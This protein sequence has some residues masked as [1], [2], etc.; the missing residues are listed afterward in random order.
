[1]S[2]FV[3]VFGGSTVQP[4]DVAF[5]A[6]TL[7]ASIVLEWPQYSVNEQPLAR[8]MDIS[9]A[10]AA[11]SVTL[12]D[13]RAVTPGADF[14]VTNRGS[15]NLPIL[16]AAGANQATL[17]VGASRYFYLTDN[18]TEAGTWA[19]ML[20]GA[21]SATIDASQLAGRG[22]QARG[23]LLDTTVLT[24]FASSN[25]ALADTDR[26]TLVVWTGGS[27]TLTLPANASLAGFYCEIRNSGTGPLVL[28]GNGAELIDGAA[29]VTLLPRETL[30]LH[31]AQGVGAYTVGRRRFELT[32]TT[33]TVA[34]G[35]RILT[36]TECTDVVQNYAGTLTEDQEV[37][38]ASGVQVY[39]VSNNTSGPWALTF[40]VNGGPGTPVVVP[41]GQ[42]AILVSTGS[43]VINASTTQAGSAA[44]VLASGSASNPAISMGSV[45]NGIYAPGAGTVGVSAG[46]VLAM[47]VAQGAVTIPSSA[48]VTHTLN[49][50]TSSVTSVLSG[51]VGFI[52]RLAFQTAGLMRWAVESTSTAE[53]GS[54]AGSNLVVRSYTDAGAALTD[55]VTL[56]R[57]SGMATL[58][59]GLTLGGNVVA[60]GFKATGLGAGTAAGDSLRY[61]Q[62]FAQGVPLDVAAA[63]TT[64]I[65][66]Q[67]STFLR[68]TG[69]GPTTINSL[70][71]N[72]NGPRYLTFVG[73]GSLTYNAT[74]LQTPSGVNL[75]FVAGDTVVAVPKA[76]T[77]GTADGWRVAL[78]EPATEGVT[79]TALQSQTYVAY[80]TAGSGSAYTLT[81]APALTAYAE[82]QT[83][84]VEFHTASSG[85]P[86]LNVNSLGARDLQ[87]A[88]ATGALA[89]IGTGIPSGFRATVTYDGAVFVVRDRPPLITSVGSNLALS[90][91]VLSASARAATRQT[92]LS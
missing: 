65:G 56:N 27:G 20:F 73:S 38:F 63:A 55:V 82:N 57:A 3:D 76:T 90:A 46:G 70:G 61:E 12:P 8:V 35:F 33:F 77:S 17:A 87:W 41:A 14:L 2:G 85:T 15:A 69:A 13:A 89:S 22:L 5:R 42:N 71:T 29:S 74:T 36:P 58:G 18:T 86:T 51:A 68:V 53:S 47:S 43:E 84:D 91:G 32:R 10:N 9:S 72:Y 79:P 25:R 60:A 31:V 23:L 7:T 92:V 21:A 26:A 80:A 59:G 4:S 37:W 81:A 88:G 48:S 34:G 54:N 50:S 6:I 66:A 78:R 75:P 44:L 49:T 52:K 19:S 39:Y 67:N 11:Y 24:T 83:F 62:L 16:N 64:D 1:M 45:N 30:I 40:A 28:D